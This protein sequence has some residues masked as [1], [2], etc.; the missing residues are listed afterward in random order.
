[1]KV[2]FSPPLVSFVD[3]TENQGDELIIGDFNS[4]IK[5]SDQMGNFSKIKFDRSSRSMQMIQ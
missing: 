3:D 5:A 2:S 1:M 4:S